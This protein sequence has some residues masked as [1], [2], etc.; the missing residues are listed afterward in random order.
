VETISVC[1]LFFSVN[2]CF[3][4][5]FSRPPGGMSEIKNSFTLFRIL[6]LGNRLESLDPLTQKQY[7]AIKDW[8]QI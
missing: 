4:L 8:S 2:Y 7:L 1:Y 5:S 6:G 3:L